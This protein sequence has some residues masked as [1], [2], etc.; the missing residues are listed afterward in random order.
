MPC[1]TLQDIGECGCTCAS[2]TITGTVTGC[3][4][5]AVNGLT[6]EARDST[7]TGT[8]LGSTTTNSSGAYT[9]SGLTGHVSGNAIVLVFKFGS[10]FTTTT[11]TLSYTTGT[12]TSTQ[13]SC[14]ASTAAGTKA[15]GTAASGYHCYPGCA[16]PLADTL[17]YTDVNGTVSMTYSAGAWR[18]CS[19]KTSMSTVVTSVAVSC[20][21]SVSTTSVPYYIELLDTTGVLGHAWCQYTYLGGTNTYASD[22]TGN[23]ASCST[24]TGMNCPVRSGCSATS[25]GT[26]TVTPTK[27]C[28]PSLS[29]TGTIGDGAASPNPGNGTFT[30][31]E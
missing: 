11:T 30:I 13:W 22:G 4:S 2:P 19:T 8:L 21:P 18:A 3:G 15:M 29:L 26:A 5:L 9:L 1:F 10:R 17:S 23:S 24:S 12:P 14:G 28:P 20:A 27:V 6:V 31:T 7:S 25:A 16:I